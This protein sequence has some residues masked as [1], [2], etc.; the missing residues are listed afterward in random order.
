MGMIDARSPADSQ[1]LRDRFYQDQSLVLYKNRGASRF[2]S[3]TLHIEIL[4]RT[5]CLVHVIIADW[6]RPSAE[7]HLR[8]PEGCRTLEMREIC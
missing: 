4:E 5:L 6:S 1:Y 2:Y 8:N 3:A 7:I